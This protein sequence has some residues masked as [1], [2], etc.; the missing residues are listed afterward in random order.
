[1]RP[2]STALASPRAD[3]HTEAVPGFGT[4]RFTPVDPAADSA[5][6]H[7][8]VVEERARFWGMNGASREL[9]Q[10]IY[11]DVDRRDTHHAYMVRL[12]DE[13]VALFQTYQPAEDR[14]SLCY[15][16]REGDIGVHLM[17]APA[18]GRPRPGFSRTLIGS[19][20]R[21]TFRDP[22]VLRA[23][24]EPDARNEKAVALL[25]RLGF[26][27][28]GEI[29]LPEIDLPEIYLPEKRAVLAFLDRPA[30]LPPADGSTP[31]P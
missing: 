30:V 11:E 6:L 10:E 28:Q 25:G 29:T 31:T 18:N 3:V 24:G 15:E 14:I 4:V 5:V 17:L 2:E 22:A 1:M 27:P 9:V 20:T 19:L 26:V 8:W 23:V 21:F 16:V 12:D 7:S 13:P